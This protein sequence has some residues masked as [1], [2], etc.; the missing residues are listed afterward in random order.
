MSALHLR[1]YGRVQGVGFRE[2]MRK[3]AQRLG[4]HGWV[5]NCTDGTVEAIIAG[6]D[7]AIPS[8]LSWCRTGP[9]IARVDKLDQFATTGKFDGFTILATE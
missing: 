8:M 5:R 9:P 1:I 4:I 6:D 7:V 3:E 2:A